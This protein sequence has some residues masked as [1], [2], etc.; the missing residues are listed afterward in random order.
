MLE[1]PP[2]FLLPIWNALANVTDWFAWDALEAIGTVGALWFVILQTT[3]SARAERARQIGTLT[4][5][6]GLIEPVAES[7]P[8]YPPW[9]GHRYLETDEIEFLIGAEEIIERALSGLERISQGDLADVGATEYATALP[10]A[11]SALLRAIPKNTDS[12]VRAWNINN[13]SAYLAEAN[14]FFRNQR[15][16]IRHGDFGV[17]LRILQRRFARLV[18]NVIRKKCGLRSGQKRPPEDP[19][20]TGIEPTCSKAEE[21]ADSHSL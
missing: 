5:L 13:N 20:K 2:G 12:K 7:V 8:V 18:R 16:F 4:A 10:L 11:L 3:R 9:P 6:I 15:D 17:S 21:P 14:E 19:S 1:E